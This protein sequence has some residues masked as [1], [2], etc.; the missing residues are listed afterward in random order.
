MFGRGGKQ[1]FII[2]PPPESQF[3]G[4]QVIPLGKGVQLGREGKV[5]PPDLDAHPACFTHVP[6][7]GRESV[8]EI[9][10]GVR[11]IPAGQELSDL[12]PRGWVVGD[13]GPGIFQRTTG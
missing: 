3:N 8:G 2:F 13:A 12:N 6:Y 10:G 9:D 11:E 5:P 7:V 1:E 4:I